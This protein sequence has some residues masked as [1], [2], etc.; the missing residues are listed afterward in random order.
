M[1]A[2]FQSQTGHINSSK[3]RVHQAKTKNSI[4]FG[5]NLI[6]IH[7]PYFHNAA[8]ESNIMIASLFD[9]MHKIQIL[10]FKTKQTDEIES[11]TTHLVLKLI[12]L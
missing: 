7:F 5:L 1:T 3:L 10:D 4:C 8:T 2:E 6:F 12:I 11:K 9:H